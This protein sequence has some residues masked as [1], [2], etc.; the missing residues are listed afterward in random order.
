MYLS[1]LYVNI[2]DRK[3]V[4]HLDDADFWHKKIMDGFLDNLEPCSDARKKLGILFRKE[5]SDK[6]IIIYVQSLI[7]PNWYG[8]SWVKNAEV[9]NIDN[10]IDS[11]RVGKFINFNLLCTPY[12][13]DEET[14]K[15]K[16]FSRKEDKI[17]WLREKEDYNGFKLHICENVY[18]K[19]VL[20]NIG[21]NKNVS[22]YLT[23]LQGVI[24]ITDVDKFVE[25][26]KE[27][28]GRQ[29]SYGAGM[30]MLY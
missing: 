2:A 1:K 28:V 17:N 10:I 18:C 7:A 14:K 26:Y 4:Y 12:Y 13:T 22:L 27:G 9:K 19:Q 11:F 6:G 29:K 16:C 3:I 30:L 20:R 25:F 5:E 8:K 24:E 21:G 15:I 23:N